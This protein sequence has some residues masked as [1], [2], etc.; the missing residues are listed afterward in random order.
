MMDY[1]IIISV[2]L[3]SN[4]PNGSADIVN[5]HFSHYKSMETIICHRTHS[6]YPTGIKSITFV[7][8]NA[9]SKYVK[10]Q[11]HPTNDCREEDF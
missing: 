6:S 11:L 8:G 1:S 10:F 7:E 4:I 2:K 9:V 5:F 3:V